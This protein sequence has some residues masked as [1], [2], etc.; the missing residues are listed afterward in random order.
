MVAL[1][2]LIVAPTGMTKR[3]TRGSMPILS[4]QL[5]VIGI[6]AELDPVP[7]AVAKTCDIFK[8]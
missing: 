1:T 4:R 6:V 7:K 2:M 8:T 5:I 3:V